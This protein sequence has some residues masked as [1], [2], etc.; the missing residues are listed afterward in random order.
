MGE[1]EISIGV[2]PRGIRIDLAAMRVKASE[3]FLQNVVQVCA[4]CEILRSSGKLRALEIRSSLSASPSRVRV[5][6]AYYVANMVRAAIA[7]KEAI[8]L[9]G[10]TEKVN[11]VS[12]YCMSMKIWTMLVSHYV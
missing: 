2:E 5:A 12:L 8:S 10:R 7:R 11:S 6:W 4:A 3:G 9:P 1:N